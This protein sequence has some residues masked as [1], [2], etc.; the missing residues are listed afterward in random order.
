[1]GDRCEGSGYGWQGAHDADPNAVDHLCAVCRA[2]WLQAES[3][4]PTTWDL[5]AMVRGDHFEHFYPSKMQCGMCG[6]DPIVEVRL[7]LDDAGP[8]WGWRDSYHPVNRGGGRVSMVYR[9][10]MLVEICFPYGTA[11][12]IKRGRGD[13]VRLRVDILGVTP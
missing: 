11:V 9:H 3:A 4:R 12:E 13:V 2:A 6:N 10:P 5:F 1:M 7:T 8:Y